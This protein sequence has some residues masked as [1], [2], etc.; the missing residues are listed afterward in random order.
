MKALLAAL[1]V[2]VGAYAAEPA[3]QM[4]QYSGIC[5]ASAAVPLDAQHFAVAEDEGNALRVYRLGQS[6][7]SRAPLDLAGFLGTSK[8]A[9]DLEAAA[10]VGDVAYWLSSHSITSAGKAREW[11]RRFFATQIDASVSPPNLKPIGK[12]YPA[13]LDD[14]IAAPALKSLG[15]ARAAA[16][17]P[18]A[19]G[20][21]NIEGLAAAADGSLLIGF[22]N[23]LV[24]GKALLVPLTN[25]G[26]V[27]QGREKAAFGPPILLDL[28]GRGIRSIE[29]VGN[30]Y[31]IVA[32]P[33]GDAD[34]FALF[35]WTGGATE[36]PVNTHLSLPG[37]FSP[38]ALVALQGSDDVLLLSDDG[39]RCAASA[40]TFQALRVRINK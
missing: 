1:L 21:L 12:P 26:A 28:G 37:N 34:N 8:K 16:L 39:A 5:E 10:R 32:G 4:T 27:V 29:R 22:R 38:E 31:L 19:P 17:T 35:R 25:P 9:S 20:G 15:L 23:P 24:A 40:M 18:E 2:S 13:M 6:A 33:M 30:G 14:L 36:A 11:R 7:P 3:A